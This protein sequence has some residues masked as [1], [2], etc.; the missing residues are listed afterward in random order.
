[1]LSGASFT[2]SNGVCKSLQRS[3][4]GLH[5]CK[6][7]SDVYRLSVSGSTETCPAG[8]GAVRRGSC[9]Q[10]GPG[11]PV[12]WPDRWVVS[13]SSQASPTAG[14]CVF[15]GLRGNAF[16]VRLLQTGL[17]TSRRRSEAGSLGLRSGK[18]GR[19]LACRG[20]RSEG[21]GPGWEQDGGAG[22]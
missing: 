6:R 21:A 1:M 11:E 14:C 19:L 10:S 8:D 12:R 2:L 7:E 18:S 3:G 20:P 16:C 4:K 22:Q 17:R 15:P 13:S 9:W 5:L